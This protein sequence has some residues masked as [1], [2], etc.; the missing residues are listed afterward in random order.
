M[1]RHVER[2]YTEGVPLETLQTRQ[3]HTS[4]NFGITEVRR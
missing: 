2:A 4:E 3:N 1:K